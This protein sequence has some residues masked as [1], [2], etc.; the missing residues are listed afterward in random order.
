[1]NLNIV[2]YALDERTFLSTKRRLEQLSINEPVIWCNAA[3]FERAQIINQNLNTWLLFI[4]H[5]CELSIENLNI[6]RLIIAK[7]NNLINMV[8]AGLYA[9]DKDSSYLQKGHNFIANNWLLQSYESSET[10]SL[11]LGGVFLVK[12]GQKINK[13]K[14]GI[15]WGAEDKALSYE[16]AK[17]GLSISLLI[18]LKVLHKTANTWKHFFKRAYAHGKNNI[19]YI[20]V[21]RN[22]IN[23]LFWIRKIGFANLY[24]VPLIVGHFCVQKWAELVQK[25]RR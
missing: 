21:D 16:L 8:F 13:H 20:Q 6:I 17:S 5:D 24:F 12:A 9:D 15:F 25:V 10:E 7:N 19:R 3:L 14:D 23:Y 1:M 11:I 22:K 4:D 18:D 2:V